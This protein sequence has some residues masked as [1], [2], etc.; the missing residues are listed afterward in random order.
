MKYE[1]SNIIFKSKPTGNTMKRKYPFKRHK[2]MV[3]LME[4]K[5]ENLYNA[6]KEGLTFKP[7]PFTEDTLAY[8]RVQSIVLDFDHLTKNQCKFIVN[9]CYAHKFHATPMYGDYSAGTK[10]RLYENRDIPNYSNP[11]WGYKVFYPVDCLCTWNELNKAFIEAVAY[12]NPIFTIDE[13]REI[14]K[15]WIKANNNKEKVQDPIFTNW[16]L[17][18][19]AML[20]SFRTQVT[21]GV[22][23]DIEEKF[24]A[25]DYTPK[26]ALSQVKFPCGGKDDYDGL[27]WKTDEIG[28]DK[29]CLNELV[30]I[31]GK[32]L[33][34]H[35]EIA[36]RLSIQNPRDN[37]NLTIPTSKSMLAKRLKRTQFEDLS[38]DDKSNAILNAWLYSKEIVIG[39]A[40]EVGINVARTLT[41][42]LIEM[43]RQRELNIMLSIQDI[44]KNH[45]GIL[46]NDIVA[47]IRRR[48][49]LNVLTR[50]KFENKNNV[51]DEITETDKKAIVKSIVNTATNYPRFRLR[52]KLKDMEK[53][54]NP[55]HLEIL[56]EYTN[57]KNKSTFD[58]YKKAR[59]KWMEEE[60]EEAKNHKIPYTYHKRG[61]KKELICIACADLPIDE[62]TRLG[63]EPTKLKDE[64]EWLKWCKDYLNRKEGD[65][66]DVS[67]EELSR[68]FKDY[69]N[70]YNKKFGMLE[71]K[72]RK[73][74]SSKY[75]EIFKDMSKEEIAQ[76]IDNSDLHRQMKKKLRLKYL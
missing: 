65:L 6:Y 2:E 27:E 24:E 43:E 40:R 26:C 23:P 20:N 61:L 66:N 33:L 42:N 54:A 14:W 39:K 9:L 1:I 58:E 30:D 52:M 73:Q 59:A 11:K 62:L 44:L 49:G 19:V 13:V 8:A 36:I 47:A 29:E 12:F 55:N 75:D 18:D 28:N 31:W 63:L 15:K 56:R 45:V 10:T 50:K 25:L 34:T 67:D 71:G 41:R 4:D 37:L 32:E 21:Y 68:W 51:I 57:T 76:Y 70:E 60:C 17:P 22:K 46:M 38:W 69:R 64:V 74:R 16:I 48:C 7:H 72:V 35:L 3:Y 5:P 53:H